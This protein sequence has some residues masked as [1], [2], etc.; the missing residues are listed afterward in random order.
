MGVFHN[1]ARSELMS[2]KF[3]EDLRFKT[4]KIDKE[5]RR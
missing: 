2:M 4:K 5:M 1:I 3:V